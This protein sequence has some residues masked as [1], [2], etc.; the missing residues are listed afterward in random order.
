MI[1]PVSP[2][3]VDESATFP[4]SVNSDATYSMMVRTLLYLVGSISRVGRGRGAPA[5]K[6][7]APFDE[8][9]PGGVIGFLEEGA[10]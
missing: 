4:A 3:S 8:L 10:R 6:R 1:E 5:V 7:A 9:A 2:C